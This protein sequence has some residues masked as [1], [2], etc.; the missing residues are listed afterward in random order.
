[1]C[2]AYGKESG[3]Q[4]VLDSIKKG[5]TLEQIIKVVEMTKKVGIQ[6]TGYFMLGNLG[7]TKATI[8]ETF[9]FARKL[10]LNFYGFAMTSPILGTPMYALAKKEGMV[11]QKNLEDWS[12]HTSVNL[13]VDC[14]DK[15]LEQ[16]N[17]DAFNEFTIAKR[18]GKHYLLNPSLW[19]N[20]LRSL[21]FLFGKRSYTLLLKKS[22]GVITGK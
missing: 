11:T 5:I 9:D 3:N 4:Q 6:V 10:D 12:F 15:E 22:F 7:E 2:I 1:M 21:L 18:Y 20:G 13:T 14:S 8:Q 17:R 16:F 19:W